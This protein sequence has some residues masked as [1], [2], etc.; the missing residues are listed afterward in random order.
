MSRKPSEADVS[1]L[2]LGIG[3]LIRRVRSDAAARELS[4]AE[5]SVLSRLGRAGPA[6]TAELARAEGMKPQ[7]M[8]SLIG[9]LER[10][11][12]VE[13]MPHATDGRQIRI[14]LTHKGAALRKSVMSA[15]HSWL[16][17]AIA[18][19]DEEEQGVLLKAGEIIK[20]LA[21]G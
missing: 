10:M 13:R 11:N 2:L 7:S 16:A 17:Q 14:A 3:L 19:L 1:T 20:R 12:L 15:K 9:A 8:G 5:S 21:E 4:L 18:R 6:S